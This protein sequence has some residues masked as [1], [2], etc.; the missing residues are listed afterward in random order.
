VTGR[1]HLAG[2]FALWMEH[3][4]PAI[5]ALYA[6]DAAMED[7][8]LP[9]PRRGREAIER[10]YAEMFGALEQPVHDLLGWAERDGRVWFEW[11]FG[12]GGVERPLERY[13]GVSIQTLRDGLIVHD[14]A[15]WSPS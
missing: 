6:E 11:S 2:F 4:A 1:E 12:S 9:E 7:P 15:F 14:V 10:Y 3:D 13:H 5:A 8:T